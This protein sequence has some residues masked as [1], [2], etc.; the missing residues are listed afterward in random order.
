MKD[1]RICRRLP[2]GLLCALTL[3]STVECHLL[4]RPDTLAIAERLYRT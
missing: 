3:D 4:C 1:V 2:H